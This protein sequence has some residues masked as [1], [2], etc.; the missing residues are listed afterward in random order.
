MVLSIISGFILQAL[1]LIDVIDILLKKCSPDLTLNP[2]S[3]EVKNISL[4]Q[5]NAQNTQ[6]DTTYKGF[7]IEIITVPYTPT[8]N[9]F[10]AVGKNKYGII[11]IR[12]NLSFTS[13]NQTLINELKLIIDRDNLTGY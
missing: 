13:N 10:Q 12:G 6:N 7:V 11:M 8:V 1:S 5:L 4:L 3:D 9:R 2:V